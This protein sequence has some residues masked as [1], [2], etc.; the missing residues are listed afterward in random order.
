MTE[1]CKI[2]VVDDE[3]IT[4]MDIC[5]MLRDEGY[6]VVA[7]GKNGEEAIELTYKWKPDLII[8]DVK[9]PKMDGIKASEIIR[10][11]SGSAVLLLT[12]YSQKEL[13]KRAR[14]AGVCGYL[15]KP[16]SEEDLI[17]AVEIALGQQTSFKVLKQNIDDLKNKV[18]E[19]K[20]IDKAKGMIMK[21]LSLAE[22]E[23]YEW[24]RSQSMK[25]RIS[26]IQLSEQLLRSKDLGMIQVNIN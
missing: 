23:A 24:M 3:P 25:Q 18:E 1:A 14:S 19:R 10:K 2:L 26:M 22:A 11:S 13:V 21:H 4:R 8:M 15:V 9:M 5:E 6:N 17:P 7:E 16:V 20:I 12:A